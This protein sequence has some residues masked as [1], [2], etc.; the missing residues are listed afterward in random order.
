MNLIDLGIIYNKTIEHPENGVGTI[1]NLYAIYKGN[2]VSFCVEV[3][4]TKNDKSTYGLFGINLENGEITSL[5]YYNYLCYLKNIIKID[6]KIGYLNIYKM[7]EKRK[8][9]NCRLNALN[10]FITVDNDKDSKC[11]ESDSYCELLDNGIKVKPN[12][13][14]LHISS[15]LSTSYFEINVFNCNKM[16]V[17]TKHIKFYDDSIMHKLSDILYPQIYKVYKGRKIKKND[18][19]ESGLSIFLWYLENEEDSR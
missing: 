3:K 17:Y 7:L 16:A 6:F 19:R 12:I 8:Y 2:K 18:L 5:S 4:F 14:I 9:D 11:Y 10:C 15:G 13:A 1:D